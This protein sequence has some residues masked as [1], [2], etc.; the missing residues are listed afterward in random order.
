MRIFLASIL[1][2]V[3]FHFLLCI[4]NEILGKNFFDWTNMGE[5]RLFRIALRLRGLKKIFKIG[6]KNFSF[7]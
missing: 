7:F 3:L 1:N 6:Q 5:L 2:F 4:N